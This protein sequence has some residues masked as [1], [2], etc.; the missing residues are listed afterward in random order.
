M[1]KNDICLTDYLLC[2]VCGRQWIKYDKHC[3]YIG[4]DNVKWTDAERKC[5]EI[6][7]Y[8]VKIDDASENSWIKQQ[9]SKVKKFKIL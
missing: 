2:G 5:R 7:G 8:L 9:I 3:Y 1:A 4:D 6:G